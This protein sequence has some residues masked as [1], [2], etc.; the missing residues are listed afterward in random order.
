MKL[1]MRINWML[2]LT[3]QMETWNRYETAI[4]IVPY[5]T[6]YGKRK[7]GQWTLNQISLLLGR[8]LGFQIEDWCWKDLN[9]S[10]YGTVSYLTNTRIVLRTPFS[11]RHQYLRGPVW[12]LSVASWCYRRGFCF[13]C[14]TSF[15]RC[16]SFWQLTQTCIKNWFQRVREYDIQS[17][18]VAHLFDHISF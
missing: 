14:E 12:R 2:R 9:L 7:R 5:V 8:R 17:S 1:Q 10:K 13:F 16:T 6:V 15:S 18:T 11:C 3:P 4:M